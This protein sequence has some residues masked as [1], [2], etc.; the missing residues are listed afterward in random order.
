MTLIFAFS[1]ADHLYKKHQTVG[2]VHL[3]NTRSYHVY[4]HDIFKVKAVGTFDTH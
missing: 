1:S 4:M 3:G 2:K